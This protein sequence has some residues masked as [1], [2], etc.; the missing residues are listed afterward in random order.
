[1]GTTCGYCQFDREDG[2]THTDLWREVA[3]AEARAAT[4]ERELD[5]A[6]ADGAT[7]L[8]GMQAAESALAAARE[9]LRD[10]LG[11][12]ADEDSGDGRGELI[13]DTSRDDSPDY[14]PRMMRLVR[15]IARAQQIAEGAALPPAAPT[16]TRGDER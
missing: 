14:L 11:C 12:I 3:A 10:L 5:H 7:L 6:N 2:C 15:I 4:L 8:A 1:M 13:R 16:E 9:A